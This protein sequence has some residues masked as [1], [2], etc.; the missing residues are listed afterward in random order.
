MKPKPYIIQSSRLVEKCVC[1][2][3]YGDKYVVSKLK[4][5]N[6]GLDRI[7]NA[8]NAYIRGGKNNPSGLYYHLFE[9]VM[10]NPGLKFKVHVLLESENGYE[11]LKKEQMELDLG[12]KD[13]HF[14]NN[15]IQAYIP[16]YDPD[17]KLHGWLTQNEVLNFRKWLKKRPKKVSG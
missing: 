17:T 7:E 8:L 2:I 3:N 11:L 6:Q 1:R 16:E 5:L 12:R 4:H 13:P 14:L 9:H 10:K 15:Q